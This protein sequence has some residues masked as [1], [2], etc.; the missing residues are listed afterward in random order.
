MYRRILVP[1]DGSE[2]A[3][4]ALP[5]ANAVAQAFNASVELLQVVPI[6]EEGSSAADR[7]VGWEAEVAEAREYLGGIATRFAQAGI[8][9][10]SNVTSGSVADEILRFCEDAECD[11]IVMSTHG[12]SGLGRWVYGSIAD[13][14][15]RH[16]KVPVLL[17]RTGETD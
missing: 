8:E 4:Q 3:E 6:P 2:L 7:P 1:L 17:V 16:A 5:H 11:L 14:L 13:R 15:L 12:R 9:C 10:H